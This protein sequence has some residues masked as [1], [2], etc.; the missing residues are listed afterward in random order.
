MRKLVLLSVLIAVSNF[1][2]CQESN[3]AMI[4]KIIKQMT[5][6]EKIKM[7]GG[8]PEMT[9]Y[10]L[11]RLGIPVAQMSDGPVGVFMFGKTTAYAA[12][13]ALA[14]TWN[15]T[16][17]EKVGNSIGK[18]ARKKGV[19]I[20]LAP[21]MNIYRAPMCGRNFEYLGED[22]FLAGKIASSYIIGMQKEKVMAC[23]KHFAANN[24]EFDRH[25]VSS[26]MELRTLHEIYFPAFKMCVEEG[27]VATIMTSY[28]LINGV[29]ASQNDYLIKK[30]L[31]GDINNDDRVNLIDFSIIAYI[32]IPLKEKSRKLFF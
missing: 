11:K 12:S 2:F 17:A 24:Q 18:E 15:K 25:N 20:M 22:P 8:A 13:V 19:N 3:D 21:G 30:V 5:I 26:D 1:I 28:N 23:A 4:E 14:A 32:T 29:H 16:L 7:I 6:E 31:K 9:T 27:K 10:P